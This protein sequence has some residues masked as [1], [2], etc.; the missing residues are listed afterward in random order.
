MR[1]QHLPYRIAAYRTVLVQ[2]PSTALKQEVLELGGGTRQGGLHRCPELKMLGIMGV[3]RRQGQGHER[4]A[5]GSQ[6]TT[7]SQVFAGPAVY[8]PATRGQW[9]NPAVPTSTPTPCREGLEAVPTCSAARRLDSSMLLLPYHPIVIA[10]FS[11][12]DDASATENG[13]VIVPILSRGSAD[14][15]TSTCGT[16]RTRQ[17]WVEHLLG[18]VSASRAPNI[19]TD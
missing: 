17:G 4:P 11:I 6:A 8:Y 12:Q 14:W 16:Q 10:R 15:H 1:G 3:A 5:P 19:E 18:C 13:R 2:K 7:S 9:E